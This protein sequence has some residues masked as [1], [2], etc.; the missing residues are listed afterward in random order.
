MYDRYSRQHSRHWRDS[1]ETLVEVHPRSFGVS[2][3]ESTWKVLPAAL[4]RYGLGSDNW[5]TYVLF[6][7]YDTDAQGRF[8]HLEISVE[9]FQAVI[10]ISLRRP[11]ETALPILR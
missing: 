2:A 4:D 10:L 9:L 5:E 7:C 1:I 8:F 11:S 3:D 6:I